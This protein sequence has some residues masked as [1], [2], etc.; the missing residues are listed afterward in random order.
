MATT[1]FIQCV[2]VC[3]P[4]CMS[5]LW[6][7]IDC[8]LKSVIYIQW[9]ADLFGYLLFEDRWEGAFLPPKK[10][11]VS[12]ITVRFVNLLLFYSLLY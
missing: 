5:V 3:P 9:V 8:V 2:W 1:P 7:G 4:V 11:Q 10:S 6:D 12:N